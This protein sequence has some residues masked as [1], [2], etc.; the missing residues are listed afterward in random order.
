M[1]FSSQ[2]VSF[3]FISTLVGSAF[4]DFQI[5]SPGGPN[6]WWVAQS[7]N[8]LV[9]ACHDNPPATTYQLLLNNT[10]PTI[11]AAPQ[12]IVANIANADCSHT[13]TTQQA[14]LT[15]AGGYTVILASA[16][17]QTKVYAVSQP[18]EVKALGAA[19]PPASA[20]PSD[21]PTVS[22]SGSASGS[23]TSSGSAASSTKKSN[24]AFTTSQVSAAGAGVL[25]A[26]GVAIG[27]L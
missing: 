24:G 23:G 17:D 12:A 8:T 25:A 5:L 6:L 2:L 18:F 27:M 1:M 14:A 3:A 15:A 16:L 22:A 20:T 19:Y 26:I 21:D 10:N 13:I 9:W 4:A 11:L 7:Q